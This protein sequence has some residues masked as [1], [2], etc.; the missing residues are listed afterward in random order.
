M[1][2]KIAAVVC[3]LVAASL[4]GY[5]YNLYKGASRATMML[6]ADRTT[7]ADQMARGESLMWWSLCPL[8]L[9]AMFGS[10]AE[11]TDHLSRLRR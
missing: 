11:I 9:T 6:G 1:I 8:A 5:G 7:L 2:A 3:I 4:A 10:L